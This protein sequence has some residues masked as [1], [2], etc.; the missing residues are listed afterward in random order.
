[1]RDPCSRPFGGVSASDG[2]G[3]GALLQT[4]VAQSSVAS[5]A[6]ESAHGNNRFSQVQRRPRIGPSRDR[7]ASGSRRSTPRQPSS[8]SRGELDAAALNSLVE[9]FDDAIAHDDSDVVVDLADVDF[10]GAAW[11]GTLVRS[12][13]S[14]HAQDR[15]LTVRSPSRVVHRLLDLCGLSYLI[16]P[17]AASSVARA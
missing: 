1:M 6:W 5:T 15:E 4:P 13:A 9:T 12:R 7:L 17:S 11:I 10:I 14:L 2:Q 16:E 3:P 8:R